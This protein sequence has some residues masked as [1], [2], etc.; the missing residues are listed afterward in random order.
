M[1]AR[2][3][4]SLNN[5]HHHANYK[6]NNVATNKMNNNEKNQKNDDSK[7]WEDQL[8]RVVV[9]GDQSAGK[10]SVI[11]SLLQARIFPRW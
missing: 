2:V 3:L 5:Y 7:G 6:N 4:D 1:Y 9:V 11:E 8:A 10:T